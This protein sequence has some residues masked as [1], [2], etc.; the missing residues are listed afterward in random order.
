MSDYRAAGTN[1][2]SI[3][4]RLD[5]FNVFWLLTYR[6][7]QYF[8]RNACHRLKEALVHLE[9]KSIFMLVRHPLKDGINPRKH[10]PP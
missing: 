4:L 9:A 10:L 1:C 3:L 5:L 7:R 8:F 2:G 6:G